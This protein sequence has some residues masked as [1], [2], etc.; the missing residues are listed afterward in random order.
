MPRP[1]Q[2]WAPLSCQPPLC[3]AQPRLST[4]CQGNMAPRQGPFILRQS[5]AAKHQAGRPGSCCRP[6]RPWLGG[7]L[8]MKIRPSPCSWDAVGAT[9][10][11]SPHCAGSREWPR[12]SWWER[13]LGWGSHGEVGGDTAGY[14]R[15][16]A[17]PEDRR[18]L[19]PAPCHTLSRPLQKL[20]VSET[21]TPGGLA[22]ESPWGSLGL[23]VSVFMWTATLAEHT[24]LHAQTDRCWTLGMP[25][26]Q[27]SV[28]SR[29]WG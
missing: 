22:V 5:H 8:F 27:G 4:H 23:L 24:K 13:G 29:S 11:Q 25:L 6:Q 26:L 2:G 10:S 1:D 17:G 19:G 9:G 16:G 15:A 18:V 20:E 3:R 12:G 7:Q 21:P 28:P 14:V